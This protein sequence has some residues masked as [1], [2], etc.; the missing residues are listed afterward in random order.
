MHRIARRAAHD[1]IE[2][3]RECQ[4]A[5]IVI[6]LD[7]RRQPARISVERSG[8]AIRRPGGALRR[9]RGLAFNVSRS[10]CPR[11]AEPLRE[12]RKP[13]LKW[14]IGDM[15]EL[16]AEGRQNARACPSYDCE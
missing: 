9:W 14:D 2:T 10:P 1:A 5:R 15:N 13:L 11:A 4:Y 6:V 3:A 7:H 12:R 16:M 8:R